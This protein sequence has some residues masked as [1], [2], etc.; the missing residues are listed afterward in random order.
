MAEAALSDPEPLD[1]YLA[2]HRLIVGNLEANVGLCAL[3]KDLSRVTFGSGLRQIALVGNLYTAR[4]ISLLLRT[5]WRLP[6]L[7]YLVLWGPDT[8]RTGAALQALWTH[9]LAEDH[10]IVGTEVRLDPA[11]P[12]EAVEALRRAVRLLDLRAVRSVDRVL[13]IAADLPSLPPHAPPRIFPIPEP[14]PPETF[15]S[16]GAGF[17]VQGRRVADTWP[18]LLDLV[19]RFGT[20]K[21]SEQAI[22]QRELLNIT[23]VVTDEDPEAPYLPDWMGVSREHLAAYLPSVLEADAGA[24][25]AYTYGERLRAHF[26][27]D[28]VA[29]LT[30]RLRRAPHSR[31]AVAV[32]W[33]PACDAEA[34][35]P[36][37]LTQVVANVV[38][39]RLFL[40][41]VARSQDLF[42]AWPQNTLAMRRLQGRLA[43]E[44]GLSPGPLTSFTVS[45]H[46]YAHD[47]E[48]AEEIA[49]RRWRARRGM[50]RDPQGDFVVRVEGEEIVVELLSPQ[51][52][53][54]LWHRRGRSAE[55]L[56]REIARLRLA[57]LPEH[58]VYLGRELQR[59]EALLRGKPSHDSEG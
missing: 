32:L 43:R 52:D 59:A 6:S 14:T 5:L 29:Q 36:P 41:Y 26:G 34:E 50:D 49:A 55:A 23:A 18:R 45:A 39:E 48:R 7:R 13:Q 40:T 44:L 12:T 2:R 56:G 33:D 47:W 25:T 16:L 24:G 30:R 11:L 35:H 17:T 28:Q 31:R 37:C 57:S 38:G 58:Y 4:G 9:G 10:R 21:P 19:L 20:V 46:L 54:V 1:V 53:R 15:P 27:L 51:G 3:W 8:T 22:P 42:A